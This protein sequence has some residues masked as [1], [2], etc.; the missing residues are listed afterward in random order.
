MEITREMIEARLADLRAGQAKLRDDMLAT[1]GAIQD[2]L[3]WLE[4]A[5][6]ADPAE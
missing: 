5:P 3:Y 6:K 2:C 1:D 4:L